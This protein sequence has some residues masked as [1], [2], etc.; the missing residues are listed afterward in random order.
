M[1]VVGVREAKDRMAGL[2]D[3][4]IA[5]EKVVI[6]RRGERVTRLEALPE[7]ARTRLRGEAAT[8][9]GT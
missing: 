7:E 2:V 8:G 4:A 1:I 3:R 9:R 5:G 6:T